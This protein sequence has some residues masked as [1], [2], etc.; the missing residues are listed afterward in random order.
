MTMR[1]TFVTFAVLAMGCASPRPRAVTAVP[2]QASAVS[3]AVAPVDAPTANAPVEVEVRAALL[4]LRDAASRADWNAMKSSFPEGKWQD[5]VRY[6]VVHQ[7]SASMRDAFTFWLRDAQIY[8]H[9]LRIEARSKNSA[10][11]LAPF[12]VKGVRAYFAAVFVRTATGWRLD[13]SQEMFGGTLTEPG[14]LQATP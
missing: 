13:C 1:L 7:D 2:A 10:A 9:E 12:Y 14:C 8:E 11:V 6:T 3:P 5:Q 4:A